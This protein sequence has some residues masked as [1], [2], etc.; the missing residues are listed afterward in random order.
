M[1]LPGFDV[2]LNAR[3]FESA[4]IFYNTWV[5]TA[6]AGSATTAANV[7]LSPIVASPSPTAGAVGSRVV[8]LR[9]MKREGEKMKR[10]G[11]MKRG[12]GRRKREKESGRKEEER[13]REEERGRDEEERKR[14]RERESE[15]GRE[16]CQ[17]GPDGRSSGLEGGDILKS[18]SATKLTT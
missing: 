1:T 5:A 18:E 12:E 6:A 17:P 10:A 11:E 14:E 3:S 4:F 7:A 8:R 2:D 15:K 16:N 9:K 13:R